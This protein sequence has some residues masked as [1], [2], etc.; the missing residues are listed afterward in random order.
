MLN[1]PFYI[2]TSILGV[3][4]KFIRKRVQTMF[5]F[6]LQGKLLKHYKQYITFTRTC[7][8]DAVALRKA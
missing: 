1:D 3:E 8:L 6:L 7:D 4:L 2:Y 5:L